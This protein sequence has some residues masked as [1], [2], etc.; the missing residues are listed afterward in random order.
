MPTSMKLLLTKQQS[1]TILRIEQL[2]NTRQ[3]RYSDTLLESVSDT[4]QTPDS[5]IVKDWRISRETG[6]YLH[7]LILEHRPARV[8]ELGTGTGYSAL[9]IGSALAAYGGHLDTVEYFDLKIPIARRFIREAGLDGVVTLHHMRI[10]TYFEQTSNIVQTTRNPH[11]ALPLIGGGIPKYDM[12]FMD[13]D[14][15]NYLDYWNLMQP[16]LN[17][18]CVVIA[19]NATNYATSM[20]PWTT[21]CQNDP[22]LSCELV[23]I[24]TGLYIVHSIQQ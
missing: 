16:L 7:N 6:K 10:K 9:W 19:D 15:T 18:H 21:H 2:C 24:G 20:L 12:V 23:P 17:P 5:D 13:A 1:E 11:P 14:K 4:T 8:L 22:S 3:L